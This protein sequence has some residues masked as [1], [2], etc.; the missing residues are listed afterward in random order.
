MLTV[1]GKKFKTK[2]HLSLYVR[3]LMAQANKIRE[4]ADQWDG[5]EPFVFDDTTVTIDEIQ[6]EELTPQ[7]IEDAWAARAVELEAEKAARIKDMVDAQ[8]A[9]VQADTSARDA[10]KAEIK[11]EVLAEIRAVR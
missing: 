11:A 10:L 9:R 8:A 2:K 7:A 3:G 6:I 1:L 4:A 5:V